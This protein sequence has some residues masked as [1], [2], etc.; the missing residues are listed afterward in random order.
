VARIDDL[1]SDFYAAYRL[2]TKSLSRSFFDAIFD[3]GYSQKGDYLPGA[4]EHHFRIVRDNADQ[5]S[6]VLEQERNPVNISQ[7]A[8]ELDGLQKLIR[9]LKTKTA[10]SGMIDS[11]EKA[12]LLHI[13]R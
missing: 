5:I 1:R 9:S 13:L 6:L 11:Q 10:K 8:K 4:R 3:P 7:C 2:A 12:K